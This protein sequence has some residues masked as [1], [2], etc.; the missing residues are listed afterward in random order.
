MAFSFYLL[1]KNIIPRHPISG[2]RRP[3]PTASTQ[4]V[5]GASVPA[6]GQCHR[7][8]LQRRQPQALGW[9]PVETPPASALHR[10]VGAP[11]PAGTSGQLQRSWGAADAAA[12]AINS[13]TAADVDRATPTA[14]HIQPFQIAVSGLLKRAMMDDF[15]YDDRVNHF[16]SLLFYLIQFLFLFPLLRLLYFL[17]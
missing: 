14:P 15:V 17:K 2:P 6:G 16:F 4:S 3:Y 11:R 9:R 8:L 1:N 5:D 10:P 12:S 7:E 13:T